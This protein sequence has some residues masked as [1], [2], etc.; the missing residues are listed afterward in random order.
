VRSPGSRHTSAVPTA[1][2]D[3]QGEEGSRGG[4]A[5]RPTP[6]RTTTAEMRNVAAF[7]ARPT[8]GFRSAINAPPPA[9]PASCAASLVVLRMASPTANLSPART[10]GSS[11]TW[12]AL[13]GPLASVA[14]STAQPQWHAGNGHQSDQHHSHQIGG[15]HDVSPRIPVGDAGQEY[16]A[17]EGGHEGERVGQSG[18]RGRV[19][20]LEHEDRQRDAREL[21]PRDRE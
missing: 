19:R 2:D 21:V 12:A 16:S 6:A 17:E 15:H 7:T 14:T 13:N 5:R 10:S 3:C 4:K 1:T 20:A 11:A 9:K 8:D 18:Q